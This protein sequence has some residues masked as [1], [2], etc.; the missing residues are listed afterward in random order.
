M[1]P[2]GA[3]GFAYLDLTTGGFRVTELA[4]AAALL[5]ELARVAPAE[6]LV[7]DEPAQAQAFADFGGTQPYDAHAFVFEQADWTL[8]EHFRVQSLDGFG[9][10]NLPRG[11]SAAGAIFHYLQHQMRR[12][13]EHVT[14][15]RSYRPETFLVLDTV[16]QA[17]LE[18]VK[19]R[20]EGGTSLLQALDRT[21]T[22]LGARQL[23][24]WLLYPLRDVEALEARQQFIADLLASPTAC[25]RRG[26]RCARCATWNA[27]LDGSARRA[28]T[29]A[30][31]RRWE[32]RSRRCPN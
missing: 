2:Q 8:R 22:P 25:A 13:L 16:S 3:Y 31:W 27:R 6:F 12:S 9:C 4:D 20:A 18:I 11:V 23:R 7:S 10:A 24:Q 5:D 14:A 17:H 15:L 29:P 1:L 21:V 32:R 28:A 26:K 19:A 30:T